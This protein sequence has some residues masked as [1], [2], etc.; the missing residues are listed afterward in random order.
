[1]KNSLERML[2]FPQKIMPKSSNKYINVDELSTLN[3]V[4]LVRR[5]TFNKSEDTFDESGVTY[6]Y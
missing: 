4:I 2:V 5:S 6:F 1:L 3:N